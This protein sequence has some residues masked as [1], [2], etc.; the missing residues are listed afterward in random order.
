MGGIFKSSVLWLLGLLV[1]AGLSFLAARFAQNYSMITVVEYEN[2]EVAKLQ[3][4]L[5]QLIA[6]EVRAVSNTASGWSVWDDSWKFVHDGNAEYI[7]DRKSTRLNSS[8]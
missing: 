1:L 2:K 7:R 5:D 8:H 4:Q 6:G 3:S